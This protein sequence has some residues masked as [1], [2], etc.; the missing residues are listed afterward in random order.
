MKKI[1]IL[2]SLILIA[3]KSLS[4]MLEQDRSYVKKEIKSGWM[5][6]QAESSKWYAAKVP[7]CV[8]TDLLDNALIKDPFY[9]TNEKDLQWIDKS[10]WEYE[11]TIDIEEAFLRYE[12]IELICEGLDTYADL[13][14]NGKKILSADNMF[15]QWKENCKSYLKPGENK[16]RIYFHSPIKIDLPKFDSLPYA[17]PASNDQSQTG[18]MGNKQVSIFARKAPF[19]YGWDWGPRFVTSGIWRPIFLKAWN[20]ATI[21]SIQ[22][23]QNSLSRDLA[24]ITAKL[25]IRSNVSGYVILKI[26]NAEDESVNK[27]IHLKEGLNEI[28]AS[29]QIENPKLWW[30]NGLGEANLYSF[31]TSISKENKEIDK[32]FNKIGLR[33]VEVVQDEDSSGRSFYFK[34]NGKPVFMKGANYI[35]SDIFLPRVTRIDY[36]TIIKSAVDANMNMLRVW[37]GGIYENDIFYDL[38][39]KNG[40]LIWQDFMFACSMY[41]GD[42]HFLKN[43]RQEAIDNVIR[44]RNHPSIAI[45]CGNNEMEDAWNRWGWKTT[46]PQDKHKEVYGAYA[47]LFLNIIPAVIKEYDGARFYWPSSPS[48]DY[49][50][51]SL[52]ESGDMHYWGVWHGKEPFEAFQTNIGRFISEYGFQSFPEFKTVKS[53]TIPEDLNIESEVMTSHQRSEIGNLRIRD[54]LNMY[55]KTPKDFESFLYVGQVLQAYGIKKAIETHRRNM[56]YCM[57]SL[58]WQI[59]DCW[60]VASWSSMDYYKRW[61]AVHYLAKK[62]YEQIIISPELSF[63]DLKIFIVSDKLEP[64]SADLVVSIIDFKGKELFK[65]FLPVKIEANKNQMFLKLNRRDLAGSGSEDKIAIVLKLVVG[66]E[67]LSENIMYLK[68]PKDLILEKP[69]IKMGIAKNAEGY[70]IELSTD[71][72]AKDVYLNMDQ[73]GFFTDNYFDLLPGEVKKIWLR[74]KNELA[75]IKSKI[76]IVSLIDS[77]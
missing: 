6:R 66:K 56:P 36:E 41:P 8:H 67:L 4:A 62:S 32:N 13:Y 48:S 1:F 24:T 12:N 40:I 5:F 20:S 37:G 42:E 10:D 61:K 71:K 77:Y 59:N 15:R 27:S 33:T 53:Y 14:L 65:R 45:W 16:L 28:T 3:T 19:H 57:G 69:E 49:G 60:P 39:D 72:L 30:P 11:A 35:P 75:D 38:C 25:T 52:K 44:L 18:Q 68:Q 55:Y 26:K 17:L 9:R 50:R 51:P 46:I 74:T 63:D 7:G 64:V 31:E 21:E 76:K 2:I 29:F 23:I 54:Y 47:E 22:F 34:V 70:E 43:V 73:D 58:Y